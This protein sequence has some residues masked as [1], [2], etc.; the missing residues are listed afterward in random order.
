MLYLPAFY[1]LYALI[2]VIL[3]FYILL[4]PFRAIDYWFTKRKPNFLL[5]CQELSDLI[6]KD[7]SYTADWLFMT[8][9]DQSPIIIGSSTGPLTDGHLI[10]IGRFLVSK[11]CSMDVAGSSKGLTLYIYKNQ[12]LSF[13]SIFNP[14]YKI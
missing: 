3:G 8:T 9:T 6:E 12:A 14:A 4:L 1:V 5:M 11:G 10:T 7:R 2:A 13:W